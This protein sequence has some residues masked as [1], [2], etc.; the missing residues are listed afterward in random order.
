MIS[1]LHPSIFNVNIYKWENYRTAY[2]QDLIVTILQVITSLQIMTFKKNF[3]FSQQSL[4]LKKCRILSTA[5]TYK[6]LCIFPKVISFLR[7]IILFSA[8]IIFSRDFFQ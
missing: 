8:V 2:S 3:E 7:D 5:I 1:N 4:F 6:R